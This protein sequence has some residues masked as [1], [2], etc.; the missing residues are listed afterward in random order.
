MPRPITTYSIRP[1][2][3]TGSQAT[4]K[5]SVERLREFDSVVAQAWPRFRRIAMRLLRNS[6]DAEDAV[7]DAMLS[8]F[9]HIAQFEGRAQMS[10]WLTS[11]VIN[12]VRMQ[13]RRRARRP[14]PSLDESPAGDQ[15]TAAELLPSSTPS[16]EQSLERRELN[17]LLVK[18]TR[19]LPASQRITLRL[20][21][22]DDLAIQ[23]VASVLEVPVG[24][25]KARLARGRTE[26]RQ[27]FHRALLAR[28]SQRSGTMKSRPQVRFD[29]QRDQAQFKGHVQRE[30]F[31]DG[32]PSVESPSIG[33]LSV[34]SMQIRNN[35]LKFLGSRRGG[36]SVPA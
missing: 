32:C 33:P 10:T 30:P 3:T 28:Q 21:V 5:A 36:S 8:A 13:L 4:R 18:L 11:I 6:E 7:Q 16:P 24:T 31:G 26:L 25:V 1:L 19:N 2:L 22:W 14:T 29:C 17:G 23:K 20:R 9:S 15:W 27:R 12:A 34:S 35:T